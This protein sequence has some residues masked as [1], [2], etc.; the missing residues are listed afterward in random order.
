MFCGST[1]GQI[2][3][4]YK[5]FWLHVITVVLKCVWNEPGECEHSAQNT[6]HSLCQLINTHEVRASPY[7]SVCC[8]ANEKL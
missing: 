2:H 7:L 1:S 4:C 5:R 8:L 6:V 3:L